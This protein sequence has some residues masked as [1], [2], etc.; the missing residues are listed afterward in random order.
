MKSNDNIKKWFAFYTKSR[1]EKSV[2]NTLKNNGYEVYL[3]LLRERKKWSDRKKWVEYPLFKS[4]IFIK[5]EPKDSIFALKTPGIV[6]MIKF[7][8][9]PSPIPDQIIL[10]LKLMIEGGYNPQPTDYFLKGDPVIIKDGPLRGLEG[11]IIKVHNEDRF[12]IHVHTIQHSISIKIDRAY[13][14]KK[15]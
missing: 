4:Y 7:G 1:H 3:P 2:N 15:K 11:E 13:L 8:D 5:I 14:T 6:K 12:I 9:S 10:S